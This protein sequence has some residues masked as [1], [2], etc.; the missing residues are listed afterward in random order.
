[1]GRARPAVSR[2]A[3]APFPL[4]QRGLYEVLSA[5]TGEG[6]VE[7][8][9]E[10][11]GAIPE[12]DGDDPE[13]IADRAWEGE[14]AAIDRAKRVLMSVLIPAL[15]SLPTRA[16]AWTQALPAENR[17]VK[18]VTPVPVGAVDWT[19]S[20]LNGWPPKEYHVRLRERSGET[21]LG[22]VAEWTTWMLAETASA[23]TRLAPSVNAPVVQQ[24]NALGELGRHFQ[25]RELVGIR[26]APPTPTTQEV[27]MVARL[28]RPWVG[29][30]RLTEQFLRWRHIEDLVNEL[31]VPDGALVSR[32][33]HLAVFGEMLCGFADGGCD[34]TA[35]A[36]L[37]G[38]SKA[39][40]YVAL[41]PDGRQIDI[42]FEASGCWRRYGQG[43][44]DPYKRAAQAASNAGSLSPDCLAVLLTD[45]RPSSGLILE[46]KSHDNPAVA[47]RGG[48][49]QVVGYGAQLAA[50]AGIP[51]DCWVIGR[52]DR[53]GLSSS[54]P[55]GPA[56]SIADASGVRSVGMSCAGQTG[57]IVETWLRTT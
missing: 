20:S 47:G 42:W 4:P 53:F 11:L 10:T 43:L 26:T 16:R 17:I 2:L 56:T 31:I 33:F 19:R 32:L 46:C 14:R 35:V 29:L 13:F 44:S 41:V 3:Q 38:G 54:A 9:Y 30:T 36:P 37:Y 25:P 6:A 18:S 49:L 15:R 21:V 22:R 57:M 8:F 24:L 34:L 39:P 48:Y 50:M 40:A 27:R 55:F 23:A 52:D 51:V 12:T 1:M 7:H 5:W 28:G 45:G